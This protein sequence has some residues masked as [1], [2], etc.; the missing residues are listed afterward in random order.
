MN[1]D[2]AC[3]T[4][5]NRGVLCE[6]CMQIFANLPNGNGQLILA[7]EKSIATPEAVSYMKRLMEEEEL[8]RKKEIM[9]CEN[10]K[11]IFEWTDLRK[12]IYMYLIQK[13]PR[14]RFNISTVLSTPRSTAFDNLK[15]LEEQGFLERI[16][17]PEHEGR[18]RP[19]ILW[20]V[21]KKK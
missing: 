19:Q 4:C 20:S 21:V 11:S 1:V 6:Q 15:K 9:E 16:D 8:D 12:Q 7:H 3:F 5:P 18:G 2:G 14:S 13:G 10:F 17:N